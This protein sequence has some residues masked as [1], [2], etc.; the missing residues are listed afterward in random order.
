MPITYFLIYF[1]IGIILFCFGMISIIAPN[2]IKNFYMTYS[3]IK[4]DSKLFLLF[5][6]KF[7]LTNLRVCG[8]LIVLYSISFL[9]FIIKRYFYQ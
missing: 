1:F 4:K 8:V 5:N 3:G 6:K 9:Y 7:F 2:K